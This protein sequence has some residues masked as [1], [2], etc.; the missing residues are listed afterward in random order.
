MIWIIFEF[1]GLSFSEKES[2]RK[3]K[4]I[5]FFHALCMCYG[6][7]EELTY[8]KVQRCFWKMIIRPDEKGEEDEEKIQENSH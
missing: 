7:P 1:T 5:R 4:I 3:K 8:T 6:E 2:I